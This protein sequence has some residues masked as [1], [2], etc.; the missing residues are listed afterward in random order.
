VIFQKFLT[1]RSKTYLKLEN[2]ALGMGHG[3]WGKG[4]KETRGQGDKGTKK[5][6][7]SSLST[8]HGLNLSYPLTA[9]L[10]VIGDRCL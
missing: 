2:R 7:N 6:L 8:Q 5:T 3:A 4:N 10:R 9:L 1:V